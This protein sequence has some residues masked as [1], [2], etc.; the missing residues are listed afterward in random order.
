MKEKDLSLLD[1]QHQFLYIGASPSR[2]RCHGD[3]LATAAGR[4]GR[5]RMRSCQKGFTLL[6]AIIIVVIVGVLGAAAI[7]KYVSMSKD[8]EKAACESVIGSLRSALN[9][10]TSK[11]IADMQPITAHNP[12]DDLGNIPSNYVGALG[13]VNDSNCQP[14][15]WAYQAGDS[16]NG[17][18]PVVVYRPKATL[19][20]AF[21]WNNMQWIVLAISEI[22]NATA[23]TI[24][25]S[26][27]DYPPA[28]QW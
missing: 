9:L 7:A 15:Q 12:F 23:T 16:S 20:Q 10:Y 1:R 14:G 24:G 28:H 25:L 22:K 5:N 2:L 17:N 27:D 3:L 4:H 26:L 19:A 6:E 13:D 8:A 11:Q 21:S 18:W